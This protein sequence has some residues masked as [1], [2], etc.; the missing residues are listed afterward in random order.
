MKGKE[1]IEGIY[2]CYEHMYGTNRHKI[3]YNHVKRKRHK[4]LKVEKDEESVHLTDE[5]YGRQEFFGRGLTDDE[6]DERSEK[7]WS[8]EHD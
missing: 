4:I 7:G 5:K 1:H 6:C 3:Y 2:K 8:L